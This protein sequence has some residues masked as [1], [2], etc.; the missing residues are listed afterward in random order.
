MEKSECK[1]KLLK[2]LNRFFLN[3]SDSIVLELSGYIFGYYNDLGAILRAG[4]ARCP[5]PT[6]YVRT[7]NNCPICYMPFICLLDIYISEKS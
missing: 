2:E 1:D 3:N 7:K 5:G 4:D 6:A